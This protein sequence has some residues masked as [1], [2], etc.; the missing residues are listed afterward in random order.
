MSEK[1]KI[2][3][4]TI[5]MSEEVKEKARKDSIKVFGTERLSAYISYLIKKAK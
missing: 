1:A 4:V 2:K 5:T 3:N